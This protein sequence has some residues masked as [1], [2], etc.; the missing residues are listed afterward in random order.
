MN[1]INT[2]LKYYD[3]NTE[4][5]VNA[6]FDNTVPENLKSETTTTAS[7]VSSRTTTENDNPFLSVP[8]PLVQ[9]RANIYDNDEFDFFNRDD[10]DR[11]RIHRGKKTQDTLAILDDKSHLEGMNE[12]YSRLGLVKDDTDEEYDDEYDDT[13]DDGVVNVKDKDDAIDNEIEKNT[14]RSTGKQPGRYR[15]QSDEDEEE[16]Q[17]E[18]QNKRRS[19]FVENPEVVRERWA[20]QRAAWQQRHQPHRS[21]GQEQQHDVVG[22]ARGR[23]QTAAVAHNR[24]WKDSHKGSQAN[25][26]RRDRAAQKLNRGL[27]S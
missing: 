17:G 21:H 20:Q 13:Y 26:N 15:Q 3:N 27:L 9:Q 16:N 25:H 6:L 24:R 18:D 4:R 22:N 5:L 14:N 7:G 19:Q 23:G 8:V 10:V 11:S 2:C 1:V 12:R